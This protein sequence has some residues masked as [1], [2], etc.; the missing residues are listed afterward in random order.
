MKF[1]INNEVQVKLTDH[2]KDIY[3]HRDDELKKKYRQEI[4]KPKYPEVDNEGYTK[5]QLWDLMYIFGKH[6][7]MGCELPFE[8]EIEIIQKHIS[9]PIIPMPVKTRLK[10]RVKP[11]ITLNDNFVKQKKTAKK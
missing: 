2:G 10:I 7:H 6:I 5:F 4:I 1:N 8:T 11:V 9:D 3:Y